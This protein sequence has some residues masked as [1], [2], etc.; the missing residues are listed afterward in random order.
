MILED[1]FK[2]G[3]VTKRLFHFGKMN[4]WV[5]DGFMTTY[6][7]LGVDLIIVLL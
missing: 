1:A 6:K 5:Y 7:N 2:V 4:Q 3:R